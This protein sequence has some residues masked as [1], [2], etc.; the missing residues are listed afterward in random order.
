MD[1][2]DRMGSWLESR[3]AAL[4]YDEA[5]FPELAAQAL[6]EHPPKDLEPTP[7]LQWAAGHWLDGQVN[8]NIPFG[9]PPV[10]VFRAPRFFMELLF[11]LDG[12]TSVHQHAFCGAFHVVAGSSV[13]AQHRF[14]QTRRCSSHFALGNLELERAELLLPGTTR[15]IQSGRGFIHSLFH[16]ERPSV[17]LVVRTYQNPDQLPQFDYHRP[18]VAKSAHFQDPTLAQRLRVLKT[19]ASVNPGAYLQTLLEVVKT[20]DLHTAY[21]CLAQANLR[22]GHTRPFALLLEDARARHGDAVELLARVFEAQRRES[23]LVT[24]RNLIKEPDE[25]Y[26]LA[27]LLNLPSRTAILSL[28]QQRW[29]ERAPAQVALEL[30]EKVTRPDADPKADRPTTIVWD[31]QSRSAA[32][33][34]LEGE[35]LTAVVEG[36]MQAARERLLQHPYR[37]L[38]I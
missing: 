23:L 36:A 18:H 9:E 12:T 25:R 30:L 8:P 3:W 26:F 2:F 1:L 13:H 7:L 28:V 34:L 37:H 29:P 5:R 31:P 14:H 27:L 24:Q 22:L 4:D 20:V 16:L 6:S 17:T 35:A 11:W 21:E 33:S 38:F 15:L 19:L 32:R 10:T